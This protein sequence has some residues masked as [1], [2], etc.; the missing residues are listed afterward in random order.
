MN[1]RCVTV[2]SILSAH[3]HLG[4]AQV[5]RT[6]LMKEVFLVETIRPLY[7]HWTKAFSFVR[8]LY[9]PYCE[10]VFHALDMLIFHGLV[11]VIAFESTRGRVEAEYRITETGSSILNTVGAWQQKELASD[12]IWA[13]QALGIA[14]AKSI[15]RLVYQE[16]AF[17]RILAEHGESGV[18][19][20][21]KTPIPAVTSANNETL[22][23]LA[24]L[25]QLIHKPRIKG[26]ETK[27]ELATFQ[28]PTRE[29][30]RLFLETL[31]QS[32]PRQRTGAAPWPSS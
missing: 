17:V 28:L 5:R 9:G 6:P 23:I 8:Y 26:E 16:P 18:S 12:L 15:T 30:V 10:G 13:L 20:Y 7:R 2:L 3:K 31:A 32:V 11:E 14:Q 25:Q 21:A 29:V 27:A 19:A 22:T 1:N 24:T 4:A